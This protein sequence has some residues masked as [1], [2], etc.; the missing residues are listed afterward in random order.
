MNAGST[1]ATKAGADAPG[2]GISL[3]FC[4]RGCAKTSSVAPAAEKSRQGVATAASRAS[5]AKEDF[6]WDE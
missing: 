1:V 5:E 3:C 4:R 2:G 6:T